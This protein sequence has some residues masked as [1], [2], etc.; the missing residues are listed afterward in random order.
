MYISPPLSFFFY[1][2]YFYDGNVRTESI[3]VWSSIYLLWIMTL[4]FFHPVSKCQFSKTNQIGDKSWLKF[5]N[6]TKPNLFILN[7]SKHECYLCSCVSILVENFCVLVNSRHHVLFVV[8]MKQKCKR[9][10]CHKFVNIYQF[11]T[12][13]KMYVHT[14]HHQT[15]SFSLICKVALCNY[16]FQDNCLTMGRHRFK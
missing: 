5:Y 14:E 9:A 3:S 10:T 13:K 12:V 7:L 16:L 2:F 8:F 15:W 11:I 1:T 6:I 4:S